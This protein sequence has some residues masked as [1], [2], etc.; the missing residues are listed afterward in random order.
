MTRDDYID[1][2]RVAMDAEDHPRWTDTQL[3][4]C[5]GAVHVEEWGVLLESCPSIRQQ[6]LTL[7]RDASGRVPLA[8]LTSPDSGDA[9]KVFYRVIDAEDTEYRAFRVEDYSDAPSRARQGST[10]RVVR[11]EGDYLQFT[12]VEALDV[13]ITVN[14]TPTPAHE[15]SAGSVALE[16]PRGHEFVLIYAAAALAL[17]KGGT[18]TDAAGALNA[19]ATKYRARMTQALIRRFGGPRRVKY[20]DTAAQ[21]GGQ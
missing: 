20:T 14:H 1:A 15:L 10:S 6:T 8:D 5:L 7:T 19:V 11:L 17:M 16:W 2:M 21:W 18:E 13:R 9:Q 4:L 3:A 12:P